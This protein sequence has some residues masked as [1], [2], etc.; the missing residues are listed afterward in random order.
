MVPILRGM[1]R[2]HRRARVDALILEVEAWEAEG[3]DLL[4]QL[5]ELTEPADDLSGECRRLLHL[6]DG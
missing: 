3:R 2:R 1:I 4:A 6:L 5:L